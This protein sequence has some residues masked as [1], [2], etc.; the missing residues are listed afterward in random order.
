M[1]APVFRMNTHRHRFQTF[2]MR[3]YRIGNLAKYQS[4]GRPIVTKTKDTH[5]IHSILSA[6][7][8]ELQQQSSV[9]RWC[10][11]AIHFAHDNETLTEL[12][13]TGVS[14]GM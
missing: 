12:V 8:T 14:G 4:A 13:I 10:R 3:P 6:H 5:F 1:Q 9:S 11:S 2:Q 7:E